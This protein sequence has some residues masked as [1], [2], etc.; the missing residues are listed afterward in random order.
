MKFSLIVSL[1]I[2]SVCSNESA[3]SGSPVISPLDARPIE[4]AIEAKTADNSLGSMVKC[5]HFYNTN[6]VHGKFEDVQI[7]DYENGG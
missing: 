6:V 1:L 7:S 4:R 3:S 2:S 5:L